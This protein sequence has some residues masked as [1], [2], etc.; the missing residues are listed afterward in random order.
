MT[1]R[2]RKRS[3]FFIEIYGVLLVSMMIVRRKSPHMVSV[4]ENVIV[5]CAQGGETVLLM[6]AV[7]ADFDAHLTHILT[8]KI[9]L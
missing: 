1:K 4:C 5:R 9:R 7:F 2:R 6:D 3:D 8:T